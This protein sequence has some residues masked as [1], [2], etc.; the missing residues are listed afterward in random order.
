MSSLTKPAT[1]C[2]P[3]RYFAGGL[4]LQSLLTK[5]V[6]STGA[7]ISKYFGAFAS[8]PRCKMSL[9]RAHTSGVPGPPPPA[10]VFPVPA[11]TVSEVLPSLAV[12]ALVHEF[13]GMHVFVVAS[14]LGAQAVCP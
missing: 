6:L 8:D 7:M 10:I 5:P 13:C 3:V 4:G 2:F 14:T 12:P 9:I 1:D 11:L